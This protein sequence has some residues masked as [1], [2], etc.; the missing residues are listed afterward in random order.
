MKRNRLCFSCLRGGHTKKNCRTRIKCFKCKTKG[1]HSALCN[2]LQ[3]QT[4]SYVTDDNSKEDSST[5][6][7]KSN[8][9]ILLQTANTIE[10]DEKENPCG[11]KIFLDLGSQ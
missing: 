6:L 10:T 9:S 2:L 4:Q 3:K 5:N 11:V 1:Q 7:V 8:T